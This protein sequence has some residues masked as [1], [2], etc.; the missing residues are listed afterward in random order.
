MGKSFEVEL[1][2]PPSINHYYVPTGAK[3]RP[4]VLSQTAKTYRSKVYYLLR[5][6]KAP[7]L[8]GQIA[9]FVETNAIDK[10]VRDGDNILKALFDSLQYAKL[11]KNDNQIAFHLV[12]RNPE[13]L[14]PIRLLAVE[15]PNLSPLLQMARN[16]T[17]RLAAPGETKIYQKR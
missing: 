4:L 12:S 6:R 7:M 2:W 11:F 14:A 10:R 8:V 9:V 1:P 3:A 17:E 16:L 15:V 13:S 5:Q